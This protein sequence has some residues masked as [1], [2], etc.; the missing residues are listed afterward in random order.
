MFNVINNLSW[1]EVCVFEVVQNGM[2]N[3]LT[4]FIEKDLSYVGVWICCGLTNYPEATL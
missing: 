1:Q 3:E 2:F 4:L